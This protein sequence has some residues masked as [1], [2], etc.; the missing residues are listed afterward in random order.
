M[1]TPTRQPPR[2]VKSPRAGR[3]QFAEAAPVWLACALLA[4]EVIPVYIWLVVLAVY[5]GGSIDQAA[6]PLWLLALVA[7]GYWWIGRRSAR[8]WYG[9]ETL[10]AIVLC[11]AA[12]LL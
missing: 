3:F 8:W 7:L 9:L 4:L 12:S 10:F 2:S 5:G 6:I 11:V 1:T